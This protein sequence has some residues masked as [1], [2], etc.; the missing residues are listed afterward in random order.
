MDAVEKGVEALKNEI[1]HEVRGI[2]KINMKFEGWSVPES[3]S[4]QAANE[5]MNIMQKALDELKDEI[6]SG[7]YDNY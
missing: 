6:K 1:R 5:I 2:F 7:K 4:E 3:D